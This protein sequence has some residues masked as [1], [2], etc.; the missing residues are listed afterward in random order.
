MVLSLSYFS[1]L[2]SLKLVWF[3]FFR[4]RS[5]SERHIEWALNYVDCFQECCWRWWLL[6]KWSFAYL[7]S[8]VLSESTAVFMY[9]ITKLIWQRNIQ[10][11]TSDYSRK[12]NEGKI[13]LE[14]NRVFQ[15]SSVRD[16]FIERPV[17]NS[18]ISVLMQF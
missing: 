6:R 5:K 15:R 4:I 14:R 17:R 11:A 16:Q 9:L 2:S 18:L 13:S 8:Y 3:C 10:N 12:M 1:T 7:H